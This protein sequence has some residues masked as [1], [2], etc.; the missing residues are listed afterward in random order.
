MQA[1]S[2]EEQEQEEEAAAEDERH[3]NLAGDT[4]CR[5]SANGSSRAHR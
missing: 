5:D 2:S 1:D 4:A 3:D